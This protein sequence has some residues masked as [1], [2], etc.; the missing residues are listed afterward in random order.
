MGCRRFYHFILTVFLILFAG[1]LQAQCVLSF[2]GRITDSD[3]REFLD[4]AT[5]TIRELNITTTT[6]S[7]GLFSFS[8]LCPGS[9]SIAFSHVDCNPISIHLHL[10]EEIIK[11]V[12]LPHKV[13]QLAE[14]MIVSG[15]KTNPPGMAGELK[16]R[17]LEAVRGLSLGEALKQVSG[18]TVLQTGTNIY[19]PVIHGLHSNRVLILNNG[20]RQEGQQWGSEHAPEI[21]PYIANRITVI[22]GA[23]S[24]RY[25]GDA[26]GGVVLV[27]PKLLRYVPG[28]S[29]EVNSAFFSNNLQGVISAMIE[30]NSSRMPAFAW[31]LQGTA[32]RGGNARTPDYWLMNSGNWEINGSATAGLRYQQKGVEVF[33]SI[34]NTA[35]G[36]FSGSHIGNVTDLINTIN[37]KDPPDYIKNAGFTYDIDRPFQEVQ[38]QLL[39]VK[40][41]L[42]TGEKSRLNLTLSGQ[43]NRRREYDIV[44][45]ARSNPQLELELF[46]GIFDLV[47]E[48]YSGTRLRGSFGINSMYQQNSYAYRYFIPDYQTLNTGLFATEK[49]SVGKWQLE[50]GIR[51]DVK[52][53]FNIHDND[54]DPYDELTGNQL[55]AGVPYGSRD[56]RGFSGNAGVTWKWTDDLRISAT[57]GTSWRSPQ[58]NEIYSDGLHHGAARIEKGNLNLAPERANS[59]LGSVQYTGGAWDIDAGVYLK[60]IGDFIYLKPTYPPEL[61]IRGAFPTFRYTQTDARLTGFDLSAA[62][63]ISHHFRVSSKVSILRAWDKTADDWLI[64]MPADRAEA[65]F[66]YIFSDFRKWK[67]SYIKLGLQYVAKQ[68][69][70]PDSGNIEIKLPDGTVS[71]ESDYLAPP[72]AY[73]LAGIEAGTDLIVN[74]KPITI[75]FAVTNLF[76]TQYSL[77]NDINAAAGRYYNAAPGVNYFAGI[78]LNFISPVVQSP[79]AH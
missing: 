23:S 64:Q 12:Q 66:E 6:D 71:M 44:R 49:Y 30:G 63:T 26:I 7:S 18:V 8:G 34:F 11:D 25:G 47:W 54:P 31:R 74:G 52:N 16:G 67:Q 57:A 9:Y 4:G 38:H 33:Y 62:Y 27:E 3:T 5:V 59:V 56:F 61:T 78:S 37:S 79:V 21:D 41:Y 20:I 55:T 77:G 76:N 45:T 73:F 53:M 28:I 68:T 35:I 14:V 75:V 48:H 69:R 42:N 50:A 1:S 2:S 17:S 40:S 58:A 22:K 29:G 10:K 24:I 15:S 70:V 13:S 39:K 19:K 36:I 60:Q 51:Y 46:T 43:Y 65:G 72:D 32:K